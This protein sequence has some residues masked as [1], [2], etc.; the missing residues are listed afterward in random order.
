P[1]GHGARARTRDLFAR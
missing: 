1:A